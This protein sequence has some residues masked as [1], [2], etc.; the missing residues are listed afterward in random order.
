M[1]LSNGYCFVIQPIRDENFTKRFTEVFEPA[2]KAAN[3]S[4]YRVDLDPSVNN[5]MEEIE[6]RIGES[7]LCLADISMDNPNVWYE[8]GYA[9][10]KNKDV[11]MVC[12]EDR[13][14]DF[15]F[16]VRHKK[17]IKYKTGSPSDFEK[18]EKGIT[19]K[20]KACLNKQERSQKIVESPLKESEGL[21]PFEATLLGVIIGEQITDEEGVSAYSLRENM[22]QLGFNK[23]AASIGIRSLKQKSLIE[24]L[25]ASDWNGNEYEACKLTK[26]GID[27]ILSHMDLFDLSPAKYEMNK[28]VSSLNLEMP[29]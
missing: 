29:F 17:I 14:E 15:P 28:K 13:N 20:I 22:M 19:E 26:R 16:D 25:I 2:I 12:A 24:T 1:E 4:A 3:L 27:F 7:T 9:Y 21:Q 6:K 5:I 23:V 11:V 18:L 10:A 8:L